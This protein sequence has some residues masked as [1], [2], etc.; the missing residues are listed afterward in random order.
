MSKNLLPTPFLTFKMEAAVSLKIF[1]A[2]DESIQCHNPEDHILDFCNHKSHVPVWGPSGHNTLT[3]KES[4]KKAAQ[5]IRE[6]SSASDQIDAESCMRMHYLRPAKY[7]NTSYIE[8]FHSVVSTSVSYLGSPGFEPWL[9]DQLSWLRYFH[10]FSES[11]QANAR[12]MS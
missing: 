7:F 9:W 2:T 6:E 10:D 8:H 3:Q 1:L 4:Y 12:V 5:E 11:C